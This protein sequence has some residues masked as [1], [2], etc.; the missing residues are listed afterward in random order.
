MKRPI[1]LLGFLFLLIGSSYAKDS[2][3]PINRNKPALTV[4]IVVDQLRADLLIRYE[5]EFLP[6]RVKAQVG[7]FRYLMSKGAYF[8]FAQINILQNMTAPGHATVLTGSYPHLSGIPVQEW[9][10]HEQNERTYCVRDREGKVSAK[11]LLANTVGDELKIASPKSKVVSVSIKDRSAVFL[12]GHNPDLSIWFDLKKLEWQFSEDSSAKGE[13]LSWLQS[14]NHKIQLDKN[15]K[16]K[17]KLAGTAITEELAEQV[18]K[19]MKLGADFYPDLLAVSFSENDSVGHEFGANSPEVKAITLATDRFLSRLFNFIRK[20]VPGGLAKTLI[21]LTADHGASHESNLL[22][23]FSGG[24][25]KKKQLLDVVEKHLNEKFSQAKAGNWIVY[26][27]DL[28]FYINRKAVQEKD[29]DL[30]A[31]ENEVKSALKSIQGIDFAIS[32]TDFEQKNISLFPYR[33]FALNSYCP[34]R[35]GDV[36]VHPDPFYFVGSDKSD[37]MTGYNYDRLIPLIF[38]GTAIKPGMQTNKAEL[39]DL[40]PT[41]SYV[42]GILPPAKSEGRVLGEVLKN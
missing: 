29:L 26:L 36:V 3:T 40:A 1:L 41:I 4:I 39:V 22:K 15:L 35:S 20:N 9:F 16:Q 24:R 18:I 27:N 6:P 8:P 37:H 42:L 10:D 17:T 2:L 31:V 32:R 11:Y 7:G 33:M 5:K 34:K 21:V 13:N 19:R 38:A 28:N 14:I 12:G 25:L 30:E 23:N